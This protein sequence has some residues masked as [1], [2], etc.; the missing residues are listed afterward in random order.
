V[1]DLIELARWIAAGKSER[2]ARSVKENM[3]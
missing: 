1:A 2:V 3:S